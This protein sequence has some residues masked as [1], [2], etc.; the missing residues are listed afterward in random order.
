M[1]QD[2]A[3]TPVTSDDDRLALAGA[4]ADAYVQ[5]Q[6]FNAYRQRQPP[7][8]RRRQLADLR[9]FCTYLA[10]V[11]VKREAEV[12]A[13]NPIA[14][15]GVTGGLVEG[16]VR[17]QVEQGYAIGS[18]NIRLSTVKVYCT[19][20]A[21]AGVLDAQTLTLIRLVQGYRHK[22]GR[23]LDRERGRSRVGAK[24]AEPTLLHAGHAL[25]L[26]RQPTDTPLGR[27]DSLLVCLFL[28]HGFRCGEVRTL[29]VQD[30]DL[31]AGTLT[32]YR[33]KVDRTQVHQLTAETLLA[34][35]AYLPDV[36]GQEYLFPCRRDRRG[37]V[38]PLNVRAIHER[39]RVLGERIGVA[40][41]SPHDLRHYWATLAMRHGTS[42][43]RLQEAGGWT[44]PMMPLRYATRAKIANE[45]VKLS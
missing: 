39:I 15:R 36:A 4:I 43:D 37:L 7:N 6:V 45:G 29:R 18:I 26:K 14:W 11:G 1:D 19:L 28:D 44:S 23:T 21:R 13:T 20:A 31:V 9:L 16:F 32:L 27:R 25:L 2:H 34:A 40:K 17:W 33:E 8:T 41:L 10:A 35:M 22:E 5:Q 12:L 3:L 30:L 38:Q 24:K 42:V